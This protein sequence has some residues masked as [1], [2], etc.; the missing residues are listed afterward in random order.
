[1]GGNISLYRKVGQLMKRKRVLCWSIFIICL[2]N[3]PSKPALERGPSEKNIIVLRSFYTSRKCKWTYTGEKI[4]YLYGSTSHIVCLYLV[5]HT[6]I[7]IPSGTV[8]WT[9]SSNPMHF[10]DWVGNVKLARC[11]A[12]KQT[13]IRPE[14]IFSCDVVR[15]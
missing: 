11:L 9:F 8:D 1:M 15:F 6:N 5:W 10:D 12:L 3:Q 7:Y 14:H 4:D 13:F 2:W